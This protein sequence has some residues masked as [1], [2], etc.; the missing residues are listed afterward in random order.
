M[1]AKYLD[2]LYLMLAICLSKE[3]V[4]TELYLLIN[5]CYLNNKQ[6][7]IIFF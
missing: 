2:I 5:S 6:F 1:L 7:V 3:T 4:Y